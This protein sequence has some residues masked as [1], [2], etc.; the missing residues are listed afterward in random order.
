MVANEF[1]F[2]QNIKYTRLPVQ[3]ELLEAL[4]EP[5]YAP[6]FW[7]MAA[8]RSEAHFVEAEQE[9]MENEFNGWEVANYTPSSAQ[10]ELLEALLEPDDASYPW[11]TAAPESEAYFVEQEFVAEDGLEQEIAARSQAFF[12]KLDQLWAATTSAADPEISNQDSGRGQGD[13]GTR[14]QNSFA[15]DKSQVAFQN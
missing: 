5:D 7:N 8:P 9:L 6:Y 1:N 10:I 2:L 4:L 11:N 3:V 15:T 13:K 12:T 14:G